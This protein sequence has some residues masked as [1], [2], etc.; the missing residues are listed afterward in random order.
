MQTSFPNQQ[1]KKYRQ[2]FER[3]MGEK[4]AVQ[5]SLR[6]LEKDLAAKRK[7]SVQVEQARIIAQL[8]AQKTQE[9]LE[10]R[11]SQIVT[12]ALETVFPR[13]YSFRIRFAIKRGRTEAELLYERDGA[14][15]DPLSGGGGGVVDISALALRLACHLITSPKPQPVILMDEPFR[16]M[17]K[18]LLPKVGQL[19]QEMSKKMGFQFII[20][21]HETPLE[22]WADQVI[23]L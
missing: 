8:V 9:E 22:E 15:F 16:C 23:K 13:P 14:E 2:N 5:D 19:L 3:H 4:K 12:N 21:T 17:G 7:E 11:L 18:D 20:I 10:Y 1:I 6:G